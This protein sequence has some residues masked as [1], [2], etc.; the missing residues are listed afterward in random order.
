[1]AVVLV[2]RLAPTMP[3]TF[4]PMDMWINVPFATIELKKVK[5]LPVWPFVLL[6]VSLSEIWMIPTQMS[7]N[8]YE[9]ENGR[10]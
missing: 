3:D 1:L 4:I 9:I 8:Y 5:L 2:F 6:N 10:C 7:L